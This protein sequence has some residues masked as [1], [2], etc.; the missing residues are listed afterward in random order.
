MNFLVSHD[1]RLQ[2]INTLIPPNSSF[3]LNSANAI[4]NSGQIVG[5][6]IVNG[7]QHGFI[8]TPTK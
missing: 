4:N 8:L 6:G 3:I 1:G 7:Q 5:T 2:D